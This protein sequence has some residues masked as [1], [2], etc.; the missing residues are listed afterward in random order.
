MKKIAIYLFSIA[1]TLSL[2]S[3]SAEQID[4]Y[5]TRVSINP[6]GTISVSENIFYNFGNLERHGIFRTIPYAKTNVEGKKYI[7]KFTDFKV[8]GSDG[9]KI[10][11]TKTVL[12]SDKL[13]ELKIGDANKYVT[14]LQEYAI[15]YTVSGALTYFS[16]HDELYW[17]PQGTDW[18]VPVLNSETIVYLPESAQTEEIVYKCFTGGYGETGS[19]CTIDYVNGEVTI[20]STG[21]HEP[22][23]GLSFVISLP[24]GAVAE[25]LPK[26]DL[27]WILQYILLGILGILAILWYVYVPIK[28]LITRLSYKKFL[29]ENKKVV[30]AWFEP[31]K[32]DSKVNY[33]PAETGLL[34]DK[35]P[36]HKEVTATLIHLAQRGYLKIRKEESK[37]PIFET[38]TF[39]FDLLKDFSSDSTL[40]KYEK[41][42]LDGIF[43]SG[44]STSTKKLKKSLHLG[45]KIQ[46]FMTEV[47]S[48][49]DREQLLEKPLEKARATHLLLLFFSLFT[50]NLFLLAVVGL[51]KNY[52]VKFTKK[53]V[54]KF[55]ETASL[56]N[57]LISQ[58]VQ[59]DFQAQNQLFFEKLLPY[60]TAFG[61]EDIWTTRFK[62]MQFTQSEWYE[63]DIANAYAFSSISHSLNQ[64]VSSSISYST[65][66]SKSGF[67][68]GFSSGGG[69]SGGGGGGGGGG[70]W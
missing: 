32:T 64:S 67:S 61:V 10:P 18:D 66:S 1:F 54:E 69:F 25:L 60:A 26:E 42:L 50:F 3:S 6:N 9:K 52:F 22:Y 33:T 40:A 7:L 31:P 19:D 58:N 44:T 43:D 5:L 24:K 28:V 68:S 45:K 29:N 38:D 13:I 23:T 14:G 30:A 2:F 59:L 65:S 21:Q 47:E 62:D 27:T 49:L 53:G 56:Y 57:F 17:N 16:D 11:F 36:D 35:K 20:N 63:G 15:S 34:I 8:T 70:S 55:S 41:T 37:L 51:F 46:E 4:Q 48:E 39:T 12:F